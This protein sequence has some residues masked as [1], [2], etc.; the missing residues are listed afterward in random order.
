MIKSVVINVLL[1]LLHISNC[2]GEKEVCS[3]ALVQ[4]SPVQH[5]WAEDGLEVKIGNKLSF[6]LH[7][8]VCIRF[9]RLPFPPATLPAE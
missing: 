2:N 9:Q 3:P 7:N 4:P 5:Q 6:G 1:I 8:K